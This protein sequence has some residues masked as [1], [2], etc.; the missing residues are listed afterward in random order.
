LRTPLTILQGRIEQAM[1]RAEQDAIHGDLADMLDEVGRLAAITRKLLLSQAN[2]GRLALNIERVDLSGM[3]DEMLAD[4]QLL[5]G[6]AALTTD[7]ERHLFVDADSLLL[8][9]LLNN[10]LSNA[11]RYCRASGWIEVAAHKPAS[12]IEVR[13]AN[14]ASRPMRSGCACNCQT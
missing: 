6:G 14:A 9:Q 1:N 2:S 7:I 12:G 8:R 5:L 10:L 11:V 4:A 13:F 3:L